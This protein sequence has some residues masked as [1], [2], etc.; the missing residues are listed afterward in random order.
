[1]DLQVWGLFVVR[2]YPGQADGAL[3]LCRHSTGDKQDSPTAAVQAARHQNINA[4]RRKVAVERYETQ[5]EH[6]WMLWFVVVLV[7]RSAGGAAV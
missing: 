6:S 7:H 1:M 5:A 4:K 2:V 3:S